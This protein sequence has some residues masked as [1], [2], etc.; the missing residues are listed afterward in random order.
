LENQKDP[1]KRYQTTNTNLRGLESDRK[2]LTGASNPFA[3]ETSENESDLPTEKV[4]IENS[5]NP[6]TV[7]D[8]ENVNTEA[9]SA[10]PMEA[11]PPAPATQANGEPATKEL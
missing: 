3:T 8:F 1:I 11:T 10:N 6:T 5:A 4:S 7:D 2:V 9:G